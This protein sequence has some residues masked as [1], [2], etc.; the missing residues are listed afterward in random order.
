MPSNKKKKRGKKGNKTT[1]TA[2]D[3]GDL[4]EVD[5]DTNG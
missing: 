5:V 1:E 3:V 2:V 4:Y